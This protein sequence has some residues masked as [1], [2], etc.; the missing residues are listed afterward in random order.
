MRDF[1]YELK[2]DA[3]ESDSR[4]LGLITAAIAFIGMFMC[5]VNICTHSWVMV[6]ITGGLSLWCIVVFLIFKRSGELFVV[7][8]GTLSAVG[9]M[10]MYFVVTGGVD[11]FSIVWLLLVPPI[12]IYCFKIFY[13][14]A[15]SILLG[16]LTAIYLWTPLHELGY[17]Y[18]DTYLLRFPIVYFFDTVTSIYINYRLWLSRKKQREL[19]EMSERANNTKGDFLANMSHE[20]RTPMNAIVGMCELILRESDIS[21]AVREYCFNIQN[22][23]RSLLSIIND[24]LDFSK[25]ESGKME[26]VPDEFNIAST[27]NDVINMA[28]TRKEDK[29]IEL[30]VRADPDIPIGLVGDEIRIRQVII[31]L[32]TNA[33]KF[34]E[35]GCV[36]IKVTQTKHDYGIN[37]SVSVSDTGIGIS[38]ENLEKLFNSFQQVDTKKNRAV[39]GTGLGLAISKRLIKSMGG[40][41][42]VSSVYGSGSEFRFVIP[43]KVSDSRPFISIKE[44]DKI[45]AAGYIDLSKFENKRVAQEYKTLIGE[46]GEGLRTDIELLDSADDL[47][48]AVAS[49]KYTHLFA[50]KDEYLAN[51][52]F[53]KEQSRDKKVVV[54]QDRQGAIDIPS[55]MQCIYKPFYSL[56]V[57][58]VLNN[59]SILTNLNERRDSSIRFV[60]PKARILVVDDNIIN[61]KVA[62][63]LM[64]PYHMQVLTADSGQAAISMLRSKDFHLVFMDHMMPEMDGVEATKAI[65]A[66]EGEYYKKLPIIALTA[67]A[68]NGA[69]D[70][71]ISS[72][73]NDFMPKPIEMS[74]L[75]RMLKTWLP[76]ELIKAP[77]GE[78]RYPGGDRRKPR[79]PNAQPEKKEGLISEETGI[80]YTGGDR[81]AYNDILGVYVRKSPEKLEQIRSL[82]ENKDWKNYVIE[83]HALKSS[84]LTI[85]SKQLSELAK[86]LELAGK[87]GNYRLIEEKN[88]ALLEMYSKVAA[89]GAERLGIE[90]DPKDTASSEKTA[91]PA[92]SALAE[93]VPELPAIS[94]E[95]LSEMIKRIYAACDSFDGDEISAACKETAEYSFNGKSL[96]PLFDPVCADAEDFEYD[97][98]REKTE[99][100]AAE[101]GIT[102]V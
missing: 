101:L 30:I 62:V 63:G 76:K 7:S 6:A 88:D 27:L 3:D 45:H 18:S 87:G 84:S 34:T 26:L 80:F 5:V 82:F 79:T 65:R 25:I 19:L 23:G 100:L 57:A 59:E 17:D 67:N 2:K 15:F 93:N 49:K 9:V 102:E 90:P 75:D 73:F 13:G 20:I 72:G 42:N 64:R 33:V 10:M 51:E 4:T 89:E 94:S 11:G 92:E 21:P 37:L 78:M 69:R 61:L 22:S 16:I 52:D 58:S 68:V 44:A 32:V 8:I 50:A 12:G 43:L 1:L 91:S 47:K 54:V 71:F 53:F 14:G 39:E 31:N 86:E 85:G 66:M 48:A 96:K 35:K 55:H 41:I 24:I 56:S 74:S 38:P 28:V 36:V 83:V 81:E 29:D 46:L 40:F 60:A 99:K 77:S 98:A 70:M 97:S 95:K